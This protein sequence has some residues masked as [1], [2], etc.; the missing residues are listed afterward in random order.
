MK[1]GTTF[2]KAKHI[3]SLR[4]CNSSLGMSPREATTLTLTKTG[5]NNHSSFTY[6]GSKSDM[7]QITINGSQGSP[8]CGFPKLPQATR[9]VSLFRKSVRITPLYLLSSL[10]SLSSSFAPL[11]S[12]F[13]FLCSLPAAGC[14]W[15]ISC[16]LCLALRSLQKGTSRFPWGIWKRDRGSDWCTAPR[17]RVR[18]ANRHPCPTQVA[19]VYRRSDSLGSL[20]RSPW[21]LLFL[22]WTASA[23]P[24]TSVWKPQLTYEEKEI[25]KKNPVFSISAS[26]PAPVPTSPGS[27]TVLSRTAQAIPQVCV[28]ILPVITS[29]RH[30]FINFL[31][32][33]PLPYYYSE[34][35][36]VSC[37]FVA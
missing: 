11:H 4:P 9:E 19:G 37:C 10:L 29:S 25:L 24:F 31:L 12:K 17:A 7:H 23:A 32:T 8:S 26:L 33:P 20:S 1:H 5:A 15:R 35:L 30:A 3:S 18:K 36:V 13:S 34:H 6:K 16:D 27:I 2:N 21:K 22:L 14:N 28:W